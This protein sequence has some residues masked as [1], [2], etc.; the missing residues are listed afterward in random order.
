MVVDL[1]MVCSSLTFLF[2]GYV[3]YTHREYFEAMMYGAVT[4]SSS[5]SDGIYD[6]EDTIPGKLTTILDRIVATSALLAATRRGWLL[7]SRLRHRLYMLAGIALSAG[8]L[9][10]GQIER[11]RGHRNA[12]RHNH[13]IWHVG[14]TLTGLASAVRRASPRPKNK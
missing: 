7:R 1:P 12:Y 13:M 6:T 10:L 14:L 9:L 4:L 5:L 2:P 3:H 8:F 11:R